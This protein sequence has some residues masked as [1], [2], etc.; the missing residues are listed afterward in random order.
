MPDATAQ[1][2]HVRQVLTEEEI[3]LAI[4]SFENFADEC[5]LVAC[6]AEE[7]LLSG[8]ELV[9]DSTSSIYKDNNGNPL[10]TLYVYSIATTLH[11]IMRDIADNF[12]LLYFKIIAEAFEVKSIADRLTMSVVPNVASILIAARADSTKPTA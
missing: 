4:D 11:Y 8:K 2:W 7:S 6:Q 5:H 12:E 3:M 9:L 1:T 10:P